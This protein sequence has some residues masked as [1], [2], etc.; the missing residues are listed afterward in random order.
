MEEDEGFFGQE[1]RR[2][3]VQQQRRQLGLGLL[4]RVTL[5]LQG[6]TKILVSMQGLANQRR[7][8][9]N[10]GATETRIGRDW[11]F[12]FILF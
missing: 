5:A 3:E 9:G 1:R 12:A 10:I 4:E 2:K 7:Y 11:P 6:G 8:Q